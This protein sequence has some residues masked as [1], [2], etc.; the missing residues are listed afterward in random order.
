VRFARSVL[1]LLQRGAD[2]G[3]VMEAVAEGVERVAGV[4]GEGGG[5]DE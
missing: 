2:A 4:A 3:E 5:G 1:E